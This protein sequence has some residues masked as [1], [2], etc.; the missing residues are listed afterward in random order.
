MASGGGD[1]V[2]LYRTKAWQALR[3]AAFKR[4]GY[5]CKRC[6]VDLV[7]GNKHPNSAVGDHIEPHKGDLDLFYDLDNV[8]S[9]CKAC[10]D[11]HKQ[12][13]DVRGYGTTIGSDGW[14][15]DPRHPANR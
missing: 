7:K 3:L 1:H 6:S 4:D 10:H 11:R 2:K 12:R 8:Q 13:E 14:P 9:L 5:R 15:I